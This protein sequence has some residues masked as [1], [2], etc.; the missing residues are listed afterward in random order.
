M[1]VRDGL[2]ATPSGAQELL[3]LSLG[4]IKPMSTV[5]TLSLYYLHG[6]MIVHLK[7]MLSVTSSRPHGGVT[8]AVTWPW[9]E[10]ALTSSAHP[11]LAAPTPGF[12]AFAVFIPKE[13]R[14]TDPSDL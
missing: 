13:M 8:P 4:G 10:E 2:C 14:E 6:L 7:K 5:C 1:G 12:P 11:T 9:P 3:L